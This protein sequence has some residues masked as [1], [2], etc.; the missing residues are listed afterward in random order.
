MC[1]VT[2][3]PST[4][5]NG[6]VLTSNR[7][8]KEFRP[9][10]PPEIYAY[11]NCKLVYPRDEQA[12]GSWIAINEKGNINCLLNGGIIAHKKQEHHTKSRGTVL[13]DFTLSALSAQAYFS[14]TDLCN[15]EPFTIVG[16]KQ[17]NGKM[18]DIT[19]FI[20]DGKHK[21]FRQ[22]NVFNA[23]IWSSVTLYNK[24]DR[25]NRKKWF[26]QFYSEHKSSITKEKII[27]FHSG[28][29]TGDNS[30][31]L[32]M[33]EDSGLKTLSIT[34]ISMSGNKVQMSYFDLLNSSVKEIEL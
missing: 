34:Q 22:L 3:I 5:E 16:L 33:Q 21:H 13:L 27:D 6:F 32:I 2:Y 23:Y 26:E 11:G 4:E 18:Q 7:D 29:Y 8:E 19:E 30:I 15:V 12:G 31:G 25:K 24:D 10:S 28:N 9:T 1:T 17:S 14:Q 20:W